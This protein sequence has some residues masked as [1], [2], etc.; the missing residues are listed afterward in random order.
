MDLS[1]KP[2]LLNHGH[3]YSS[4]DEKIL[5]SA[6]TLLQSEFWLERLLLT[7]PEKSIK[8]FVTGH[9]HAKMR[10]FLS[11]LGT[12][13]LK[14]AL[15]NDPHC[16]TKELDLPEHG[17]SWDCDGSSNTKVD[18]GDKCIVVCEQNYRLINCKLINCCDITNTSV[19]TAYYAASI[20]LYTSVQNL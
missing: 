1:T 18:I 15:A 10:Y 12:F 3:F 7:L 20:M 4:Y 9:N 2:A 13:L 6:L 5:S 19:C 11:F 17:A 16:Y 14:G 8:S